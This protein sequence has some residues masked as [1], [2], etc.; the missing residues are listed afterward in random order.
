MK[1][2]IIILI[3]LAI[4]ATGLWFFQVSGKSVE[5]PREIPA[6]P[7][8]KK[9]LQTALSVIEQAFGSNN[10]AT[11]SQLYGLSDR[12]RKAAECE[13]GVDP[14]RAGME[15]LG[16]FGRKLKVE[17]AAFLAV[18]RMPARFYITGDL[19]DGRTVR[20]TLNRTKRGLRLNEVV[21]R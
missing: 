10:T 21:V 15:Q 7:E 20:F 9:E 11:V 12:E 16:G 14:V 4:C 5:T 13:T 6:S 1:R 2:K 19:C 8:Q 18:D 17:N 3:L